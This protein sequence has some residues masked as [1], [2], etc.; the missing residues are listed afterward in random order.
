[1]TYFETNKP[2]IF[3]TEKIQYKAIE[4]NG[5]KRFL[6]KGFSSTSDLDLVNDI[7]SKECLKDM[8]FQ[9]KSRN[10]KLDFEHEAFKGETNIELEANKSKSPLG[11][12]IGIELVSKG[13][14]MEWELN[15]NW[16]KFDLQGNVT[17]SF[18]EVWEEIKG[19]FLDA[20]SIAF[21]PLKAITKQLSDGMKARILDKVNLLNVAL[22]G[23]PVNPEAKMSNIIAKSLSFLDTKSQIEGK[24]FAGYSSFEDC[25]KQNQQA[26]NPEAYC[27]TIMRQVE[28]KGDNTMTEEKKP[29]KEEMTEEEKKKMEKKSL[30]EITEIKSVMLEIKG[31]IKEF[32]DMKSKMETLENELKSV[33]EANADLKSKNEEINKVLEEA[34]HKSVDDGMIAANAEQKKQ[35]VKSIVN[36]LDT[37]A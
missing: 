24:P 21:I 11:K 30:E 35:E 36:P 26:S 14:E 7:V 29:K 9:A 37:L 8:S 3:Y 6:I 4:E 32:P 5:V 33:K 27:A 12:C 23:N 22:T 16:K 28:G 34:R 31:M 18:K 2:F 17:K 10:L 13:L 15:P 25:V 1:M 20:F 19:G